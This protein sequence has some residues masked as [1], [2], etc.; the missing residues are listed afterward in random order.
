MA[1]R[2]LPLARV[3]IVGGGQLGRMLVR[4]ASRMA[5]ETIVLDPLPGAPAAEVATRQ[6]V[7]A[8][9]DPEKLRE[10]VEASDVTTFDLEDIGA[11]ALAGLEGEGH[12]LYPS[13]R[14]LETIQDK[15]VQ[16][17]ALAD[18]GIP[19]VVYADLEDNEP[20]TFA[21]FGYPLVQKARRGGYD[22]RGVS[23]LRGPE[24]YAKHLPVPAYAERFVEAEKELGVMVARGQDGVSETYPVVEMKFREGANIL[25]MLLAPARVSDAVAERARDIAAR[26]IDALEGV[27]VFGVELFL[28][29]SGDLLVNEVSPRTHNSGHYTVE[30]CVTDQFEQQLRA[31]L[32]LPLGSTEQL[33]PAAM[34]NLLGEGDEGPAA[35]D[36]LDAALAIHG[37]SV[38]LYGKERSRPS[39]KM[40]HATVIDETLEG[41]EQKAEQ[42]AR[43][44][45]VTSTKDET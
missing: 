32:G 3:G 14:L 45:R 13:P 44:L 35:V 4:A 27:G 11:S 10:L 12:T 29:R 5:C 21:A 9:D 15:L 38:H 22:G 17:Q 8:Y 28:T 31:I 1:R 41:A 18:A 33:R 20:H 23:I 43:L 7:G 19:Q 24:D 30:A 26:T 2:P 25:S 16:K 34:V 6:I 40:G 39:R 36:G 37:A 42:I